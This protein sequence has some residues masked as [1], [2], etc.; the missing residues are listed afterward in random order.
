[1]EISKLVPIAEELKK[2]YESKPQ[3]EKD[4]V[5]AVGHQLNNLLYYLAQYKLRTE[6]ASNHS[7]DVAIQQL[8]LDYYTVV[9]RRYQLLYEELVEFAIPK[10]IELKL[11]D[12]NGKLL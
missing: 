12:K 1:M 9:A 6:Q 10:L 3:A 8:P 5:G 11:I 2:R 4:I 7:K